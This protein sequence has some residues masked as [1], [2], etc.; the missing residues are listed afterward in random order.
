MTLKDK[1]YT[2]LK[3][4]IIS[5]QIAAGS[6][7]IETDIAN[8]LGISRTPVREAIRQLEMTGLVDN[9]GSRGF[10][11][12]EIT[13][14]DVNEIFS[15]R[16]TLELLALDLSFDY[17]DTEDLIILKSN[18]EDLKEN[19]SWEK[20]HKYDIELHS[21]WIN[22]SGNTRLIGFLDN[23]NDQIERFRR[24]ATQDKTRSN[25][26]IQEHIDLINNILSDDLKTSKDSLSKHLDSLR[27]S[28]IRISQTTKN[29]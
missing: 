3:E 1:A 5:N 13:P 15:L 18:F 28:V 7:L 24:F 17:L 20:A 19:F 26:S 23:L 2:H 14:Y 21:L 22:R 11:V 6:P 25:K 10:F 27:E 9:Y 8:S 12:K 16:I 4:L 29:M